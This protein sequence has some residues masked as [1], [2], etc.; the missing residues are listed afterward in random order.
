MADTKKKE[1]TI[2]KFCAC[3]HDFQDKRY[4]KKKRVHNMI[5]KT[6]LTCRCTVCGRD[7]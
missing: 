7:K 1:G 2:I 5:N 6:G 4:G 3:K